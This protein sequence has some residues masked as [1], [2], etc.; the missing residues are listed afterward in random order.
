MNDQRTKNTTPIKDIHLWACATDRVLSGWGYA[1]RSS[2]VAYPVNGL[3]WKQ[4][5]DLMDW[6]EK[7]GDFI[8]V[9]LNLNLPKTRKGDH[10][11]IYDVPEQ[12]CIE[13]NQ[14]K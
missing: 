11:S 3:T 5:K 10:L 1:P 2:F 13:S 9:R 14:E 12:F 8:R 4:T 7:R 6:M